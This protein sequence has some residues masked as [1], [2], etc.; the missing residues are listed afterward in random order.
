MLKVLKSLNTAEWSLKVSQHSGNRIPSG[1]LFGTEWS[2]SVWMNISSILLHFQIKRAEVTKS[3]A[4]LV[5]EVLVVY[6]PAEC[7]LCR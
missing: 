7:C 5:T 1:S 3:G 2:K 4:P 6:C